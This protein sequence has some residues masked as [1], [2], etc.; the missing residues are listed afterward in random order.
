MGC[1]V[2][3]DGIERLASFHYTLESIIII[4]NDYTHPLKAIRPEYGGRRTGTGVE[5]RAHHIIITLGSQMGSWW[6][7]TSHYSLWVFISSGELNGRRWEWVELVVVEQFRRIC[8]HY[9]YILCYYKHI[10]V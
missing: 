1:E 7:P 8:K 10:S 4:C 2:S 6:W 9:S 3:D 5:W